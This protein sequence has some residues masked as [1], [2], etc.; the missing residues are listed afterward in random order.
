MGIKTKYALKY[1]EPYWQDYNQ[2]LL[3]S[4]SPTKRVGPVKADGADH[5]IQVGRP[6]IVAEQLINLVTTISGA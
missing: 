3:L 6:D 1:A 4:V 5:F 2:K